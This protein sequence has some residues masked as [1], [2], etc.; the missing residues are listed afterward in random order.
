LT[1]EQG[2]L[3]SQAEHTILVREDGIEVTT[4]GLFD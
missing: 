1:E 3:V 4:D 2:R